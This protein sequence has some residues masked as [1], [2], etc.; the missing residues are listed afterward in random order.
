M[1]IET[2]LD[3]TEVSVEELIR[4]LKS[5]EER[6]DIGGGSGFIT[7]L[8]LTEDELNAR[9]AAKMQVSGKGS[10]GYSRGSSSS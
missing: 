6:H 7:K 2:L 1:S 5:A 3:L 10:T 9:V 4:R 8:N